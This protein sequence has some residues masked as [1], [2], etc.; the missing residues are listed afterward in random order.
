MKHIIQTLE[1]LEESLQCKKEEGISEIERDIILDKFRKLYLRVL[2]LPS[3]AALGGAL[4]VDPAVLSDDEDDEIEE[5]YNKEVDDESIEEDAILENKADDEDVEEEPEPEPEPEPES[6][7]EEEERTAFVVEEA[8][9]IA[10]KVMMS[11][12]DDDDEEDEGP[13]VFEEEPIEEEPE[14][15]E[16]SIEETQ[17]EI[18]DIEEEPIEEPIEETQEEAAEVEEEVVE[19]A[20]V[21]EKKEAQSAILGE[22]IAEEQTRLGDTF[23]GRVADVAS[24]AAS[25]T[26]IRQSISLNDKYVLMRDLF[27]GD[28]EYYNR[29]IDK[30]DSFES[31]DEAMLYIYD[32][33]HWNSNSDGVRLLMELLSLKLL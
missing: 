23:S 30:L 31:L 28:N 15:E 5:N 17:E 18:A 4:M 29:V 7:P 1:H 20:P 12:Y 32:N 13:V 21:E 19:E 27:A 9:P 14:I 10:E 16:E 3:A 26:S 33:H 24:V 6:E 11:L 22:V 2:H 8:D 25:T